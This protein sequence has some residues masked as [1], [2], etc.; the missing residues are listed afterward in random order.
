MFLGEVTAIDRV[1]N[2]YHTPPMPTIESLATDLL[3]ATF[4][5]RGRYG[6]YPVLVQKTGLVVPE[7]TGSEAQIRYADK[8]RKVALVSLADGLEILQNRFSEVVDPEEEEAL[9]PARRLA[10]FVGSYALAALTAE[11]SAA[12]ILDT[13][14]S[15]QK[16]AALSVKKYAPLYSVAIEPPPKP[17]EK[18]LT[19]NQTIKAPKE[20]K[21]PRGGR[22][23]GSGRK[24]GVHTA[25]PSV[26]VGFRL[27]EWAYPTLEAAA[28]HND[29]TI[30]AYVGQLLERSAKRQ[31]ATAPPGYKPGRHKASPRKKRNNLRYSPF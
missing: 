5:T 11:T 13:W 21:G 9:Q 28:K 19:S 15:L 22:R 6:A 18:T 3:S 12:A 30:S 27:A 14:E 17:I 24:A 25:L 20:S 26:M 31:G 8:R 16:G 7:L 4:T 29:L 23:S 2:L 1:G 10:Q